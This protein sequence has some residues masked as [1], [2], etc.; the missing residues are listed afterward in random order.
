MDPHALHVRIRDHYERHWGA[1][2][3]RH[4]LPVP[5]VWRGKYEAVDILEFPPSRHP[6]WTYATCGMSRLQ[7]NDDVEI[8]LFA[9]AASPIHVESLTIIAHFHLTAAQLGP[10]HTVNLGRP[11]LPDSLCDRGLVSLPYLE[12]PDLELCRCDDF[13]AHCLWLIPVTAAEVSYKA[14]HGLDALES[15][16]ESHGLDYANPKRPSVV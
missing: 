1:Q 7:R 6:F 2:A 16:F 9:P 13:T 14:A 5:P 12:G 11:W 8:H 4:S 15:R 3:S 10:G